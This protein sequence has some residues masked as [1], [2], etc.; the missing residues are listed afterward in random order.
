MNTDTPFAAVASRLV[1]DAAALRVSAGRTF[2]NA[3][4]VMLSRATSLETAAAHLRTMPVSAIPPEPAMLCCG[5]AQWTDH[6][7]TCPMADAVHAG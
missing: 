2:G 3:R 6:A 5:H 4:G 7:E 1:S